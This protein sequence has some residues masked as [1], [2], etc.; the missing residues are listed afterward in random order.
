MQT[1]ETQEQLTALTAVCEAAQKWAV[2]NKHVLEIDSLVIR[3]E[4]LTYRTT[5]T[6][7][8]KTQSCDVLGEAGRIDSL[9]TALAMA[10]VPTE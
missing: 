2:E 9:R 5:V 8:L 7:D 6:L 1:Q 4:P 3:T 10:G